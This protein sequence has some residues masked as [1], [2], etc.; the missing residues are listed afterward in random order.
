MA[1]ILPA[2]AAPIIEHAPAIQAPPPPPPNIGVVGRFRRWLLGD[3]TPIQATP[4]AEAAAAP[5]SSS[6]SSHSRR[7]RG[8]RG[9][10]GHRRD[11][12]GRR[13]GGGD[14]DRSHRHGD[15]A[16]R[17]REASG[18]NR[19]TPIEQMRRADGLIV[20]QGVQQSRA[21]SILVAE[22]T[23]ELTASVAREG[24]G[25][26]VFGACTPAPA[27]G[28]DRHIRAPRGHCRSC[29]RADPAAH[30]KAASHPVG[31]RRRG[32]RPSRRCE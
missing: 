4:P 30:N 19:R 7:D 9:D 1:T 31:N 6:A 24:L 2:T 18:E 16:R 22:P 28:R 25:V 29:S 14:R 23:G 15:G 17:D 3:P 8:E 12:D 5:S 20:L 11:R 21:F 27:A 26:V 32:A 13:S 10:R